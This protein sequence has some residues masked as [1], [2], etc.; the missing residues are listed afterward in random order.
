MSFS[1]FF[2]TQARKPSGFFGRFYM[3]RLFEKGNAEL[4]ALLHSALAI[5]PEDHVFE[6]GFGTG[7]LIQE[8]AEK[9]KNGCIQGI[10]FS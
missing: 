5:E 8:L 4:N 1:N 2:S 9:L 3:S 7:Q 10:D 6:L